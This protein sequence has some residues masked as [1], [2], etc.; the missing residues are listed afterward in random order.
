MKD[1]L[2]VAYIENTGIVKFQFKGTTGEV[3]NGTK[4]I[5]KA[6]GNDEFVWDE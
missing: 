6:I 2:E 1:L 5:C 3:F 4:Q